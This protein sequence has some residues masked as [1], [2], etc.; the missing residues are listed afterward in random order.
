MAADICRQS[1]VTPIN[2]YGIDQMR[3]RQVRVAHLHMMST[4]VRGNNQYRRKASSPASSE[5]LSQVQLAEQLGYTSAERYK[6][7][8]ARPDSPPEVLLWL[9]EHSK[10]VLIHYVL[11]KNPAAPAQALNCI[12]DRSDRKLAAQADQPIPYQAVDYS[13]RI[14]VAEHP[15]CP[16]ELLTRLLYDSGL[17]IAQAAANNPNLDSATRAFWQLVHG[18][19]RQVTPSGS[20]QQSRTP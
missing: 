18:T 2:L 14:A 10:D 11:A 6:D 20:E 9:A 15:H 4:G 19:S 8:A 13:T 1:C 7:I 12:L 16:P 17:G 3:H 5:L